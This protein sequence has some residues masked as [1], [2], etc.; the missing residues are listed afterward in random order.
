MHEGLDHDDIYIMVEDEFH[1]TARTFTQHLHHAEYMRLEALA[2]TRN[3]T[4]ASTISRPVD[5]I[6]AMRA[7]TKK[8]KEVEARDARTKAALDQIKKTAEQVQ[9]QKSGSD[10]SDLDVE[11]RDDGRWKGTALQGLMTTSPRKNQTSLSGLENVKSSTRAAAGFS[12]AENGLAGHA[13]KMINLAPKPRLQKQIPRQIS[14]SS[15]SG[16][17]ETD[18]L[19]APAPKRHAPAPKPVPKANHKPVEGSLPRPTKPPVL[20]LSSKPLANS[21]PN[22]PRPRFPLDT[23]N[24]LDS[25]TNMSKN[26]SVELESDSDS[27][28]ED[29]LA[30]RRLKAQI[31][32]RMS[33]R[34]ERQNRKSD[35]GGNVDEIPMFMM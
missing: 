12:K 22:V 6:T 20:S 14:E 5:S 28:H 4:A 30:R 10:V 9:K 26:R 25:A 23:S 35:L 33:A 19:D 3:A 32:A 24:K 7:E 18:D 17:S 31:A 27:C 29:E 21:K 13:A 34:K 2:K 8:R 16:G 1:A 15:T 11:G